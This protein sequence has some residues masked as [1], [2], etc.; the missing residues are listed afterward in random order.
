MKCLSCRQTFDDSLSICPHCQ[1]P[2]TQN[3][4]AAP[5]AEAAPVVTT[6]ENQGDATGGIIPYKNPKALMAYYFGIVGGLPLVGFPFAVAAF[7][8]GI[9]GLRDRR[10][11][12]IIK[13]SAHAGIGIG[14]G[15]IFG[16]LWGALIIIIVIAI[17]TG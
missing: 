9:L 15:L 1:H 17:L 8:L 3:P 13:G 4:F 14:C 5:V 2:V 6:D 12:P 16:L 10:R 7:I 11:N